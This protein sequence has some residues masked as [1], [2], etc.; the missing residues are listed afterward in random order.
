MLVEH[1]SGVVSFVVVLRAWYLHG[2][3][4]NEFNDNEEKKNEEEDE[5]SNILNTVWDVYRLRCR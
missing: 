2:R 1:G 3:A 5:K 4:E